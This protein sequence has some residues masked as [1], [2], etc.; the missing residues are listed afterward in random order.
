ML[1]VGN[2]TSTTLTANS[3]IP[4]TQVYLNTNNRTSFN[5]SSNALVIEKSGIY[6]VGGTFVF[7]PSVAGTA[8][9]YMYADGVAQPTAISSFTVANGQTYTFTIPSKYLN[10]INT[11]QVGTVP[12]TFVVDTAGTLESANAFVYYNEKINE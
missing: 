3:V 10:I 5:S 6:K 11:R 8:N 9:I 2:T 1:E 12:I 7:T 4:F